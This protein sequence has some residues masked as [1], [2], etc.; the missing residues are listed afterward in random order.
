[1][2]LEVHDIG[3]NRGGKA[4][5]AD[6]TVAFPPGQLTAIV[7]PNGAGKSTLLRVLSRDWQPDRGRV[8]LGGEPLNGLSSLGLA[9]RRAMLPQHS[10]L[11][12]AF[13]VL[14][15]VTLGRLPWRESS[16]DALRH[17]ES[18]LE[19]VGLSSLRD[20]SWLTLSGGERQRV[21]IA[22]VLAQ[23]RGMEGG[24]VLLDEP[25]NHLD[26]AHQVQ[27]LSL[28]RTLARDGHT[29][30]AVLHDLAL[31]ARAADTV[32]LLDGGRVAHFGSPAAVLTAERLSAAFDVS[33][34]LLDDPRG[35]VGI[36][37]PHLRRT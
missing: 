29:V 2:T 13:S 28:G 22:R 37:L 27:V 15:V 36:P 10:T 1:M 23:V 7:G 34:H 31:A 4:L 12:F 11:S 26:I 19:A 21:Q 3:V 32:L 14:E 25:T 9:R 8:S 35:T 6:V 5:L 16:A 30:V 33:I 17:A 24:V 18:A 20:R